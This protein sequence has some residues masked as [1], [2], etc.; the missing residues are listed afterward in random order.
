MLPT[1]SRSDNKHSTIL[2][3]HNSLSSQ[4]SIPLIFFRKHSAIKKIATKMTRLNKPKSPEQRIFWL[5]LIS[6]ILGLLAIFLIYLETEMLYQNDYNLTDNI[7]ILRSL[8]LMICLVHLLV[9]M[10]IHLKKKGKGIIND[11]ALLY[12]DQKKL[13]VLIFEIFICMIFTPPGISS[14]CNFYQLG[15]YSK[16]T[17]TD[18]IFPFALLRFYFCL[19]FLSLYWIRFF[20]NNLRNF[21]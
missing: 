10:K 12:R 6:T 19:N 8:I 18:I 16:L 20:N 4:K 5:H 13:K 14:T 17:Y 9:I 7:N 3:H 1:I 15:L 21:N 2:K 11:I